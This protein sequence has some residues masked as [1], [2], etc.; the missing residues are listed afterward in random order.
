M[1][2]VVVTSPVGAAGAV[3]SAAASPKRSNVTGTSA[4]VSVK[5]RIPAFDELLKNAARF[6][7]GIV[8][9]GVDTRPLV[10][11]GRSCGTAPLTA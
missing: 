10:T 11:V 1:L 6:A 3:R 9:V 7:A 2:G 4:A 8:N 5:A